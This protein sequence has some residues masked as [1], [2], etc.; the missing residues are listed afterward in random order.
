MSEISRLSGVFFEP[1]QTFADIAQRPRWLIPLLLVIVSGL[2]YCYAF[3]QHV[4]WER[5]MQHAL[6]TNERMA[7]M[8]PEQ[9]D[10]VIAMQV[11]YGPLEAYAGVLFGVPVSFLVIA[12]V[13]LGI[14]AGL[15]S[16]PVRFKQ[17]FSIVCYA[18]LPG[19]IFAVLAIVVVFLK[20]PDDFNIQNPLAFNVGAFLDPTTTS[21]FIYS[22]A[23]AL[24]LFSLW[25]ILLIAT[26]LSAAGGKKLSFGG[27][28]TSVIVPWGVFVLARAAVAGILS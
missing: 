28:L 10:R 1:K 2:C 3:S 23:T 22:I 12:G 17:V 9:R 14:V 16:V 15:M 6:E 7:Q 8:P 4:G 24:D 20:N 5:I 19:V 27:A 18:S 25:T 21:K 11:K 26:G 13:L